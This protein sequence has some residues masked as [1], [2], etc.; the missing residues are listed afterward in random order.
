M[1]IFRTFSDC[2]PSPQQDFLNMIFLILFIPLACSKLRIDKVDLDE[3]RFKDKNL[4]HFLSKKGHCVKE[5]AVDV[6][7]LN[8]T[9]W[10]RR[11]ICET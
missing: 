1:K 10:R 8:Q 3:L 11:I 2:L 9:G 4:K 5:Q 6:T 7:Q